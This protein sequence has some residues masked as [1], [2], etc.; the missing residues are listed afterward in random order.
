[1]EDKNTPVFFLSLPWTVSTNRTWKRSGTHVYLSKEANDYRKAVASCVAKLKHVDPTAGVYFPL[2][3]PLAILTKLH[4][5]DRRKRDEDNYTGKTLRDALTV[6]GVWNDDHLVRESHN[7]WGEIAKGGYVEVW[8]A[9]FFKRDLLEDIYH[10]VR[11]KDQAF[12]GHKGE[13]R[14]VQR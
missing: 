4:P 5:P 11:E 7:V 12:D 14:R 2:A 8:I 9:P 13:V 10:E 3:G 1:M 6:A